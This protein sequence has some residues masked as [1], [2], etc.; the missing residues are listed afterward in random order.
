MVPAR[1]TLEHD[2]CDV[3]VHVVSDNAGRGR[4]TVRTV[5]AYVPQRGSKGGRRADKV[6]DLDDAVYWD[7][8]L[9]V[10]PCPKCGYEDSVVT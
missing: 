10:V 9:L 2:G 6:V 4:F 1:T 5:T 7:D 3:V 8:D